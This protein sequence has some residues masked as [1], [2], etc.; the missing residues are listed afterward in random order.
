MTNDPKHV[1]GTSDRNDDEFVNSNSSPTAVA[2]VPDVGDELVDKLLWGAKSSS[3]GGGGN[4]VEDQYLQRVLA[5]QQQENHHDGDQQPQQQQQVAMEQAHHQQPPKKQRDS[6]QKGVVPVTSSISSSM[7]LATS[8]S[9]TASS[10]PLEKV[11]GRIFHRKKQQKQDGTMEDDEDDDEY[12]DQLS[13]A[14]MTT[15]T[16]DL[17]VGTK[18]VGGG[19]AV[20]GQSK[21]SP[22]KGKRPVGSRKGKVKATVA[23]PRMSNAVAADDRSGGG[24]GGDDTATVDKMIQDT[25]EEE[26]Q[27]VDEIITKPK[28]VRNLTRA[29]RGT[30][31]VPKQQQ[32][33]NNNNNE[34]A[35]V[36]DE[37]DADDAL[38]FPS[39]SQDGLASLAGRSLVDNI[40]LQMEEGSRSNNT[41][42]FYD[43]STDGGDGN[44]SGQETRTLRSWTDFNPIASSIASFVSRSTRPKASI[45]PRRR[46]GGGGGRGR[47][48]ENEGDEDRP[49]R[50][51]NYVNS[52]QESYDD[53]NEDDDDDDIIGNT[54]GD[55]N[56]MVSS[57]S[58]GDTYLKRH[59]FISNDENETPWWVDAISTA[60]SDSNA[61]PNKEASNSYKMQRDSENNIKIVGPE[62]AMLVCKSK[63][64]RPESPSSAQL[65]KTDSG[66]NCTPS[67]HH[68]SHVKDESDEEIF[69]GTNGPRGTKMK[70]DGCSWSSHPN[71]DDAVAQVQRHA[72]SG[73]F[74]FLTR[75]VRTSRSF[76]CV[77]AVAILLLVALVVVAWVA[78]TTS[79]NNED[80][81]GAANSSSSSSG[82]SAPSPSQIPVVEP[83]TLIPIDAG[84]DGLSGSGIVSDSPSL[85]AAPSSLPTDEG[86]ESPSFQGS[87]PWPT[88]SPT[89]SAPTPLPS[90]VPTKAPTRSP[91]ES[92]TPQPSP[93][94]TR[95]PTPPPT[96]SPT[97]NPTAS[98]TPAPTRPPTRPPTPRPVTSSP[99]PV[100]TRP[101][102]RSPT[103]RPV[104]TNPTPAPTRPPTRSP[105][106]RPVTTNP[107]PAPTRSPTPRPTP[108]PTDAGSL[109]RSIVLDAVREGLPDEAYSDALLEGTPQH[110]AL[111]WLVGTPANASFR[112]VPFRIVQRYVLAT[113]YFSTNGDRWSE[114]S[115]W[116][117]YD[118]DE[119]DWYTTSSDGSC[120]SLGRIEEI[121]LR[122]NNLV[123]NVPDEVLLLADTLVSLRVNDNSIDDITFMDSSRLARFS[124]L[125]RFH[126]QVNPLGGVISSHL[127]SLTS[128]TSLNLSRTGMDGRIPTQLGRL[129]QMRQLDFSTNSIG[130]TIPAQVGSMTALNGL[131]LHRNRLTG[132]IP[133]TFSQLTKIDELFLEGNRLAGTYQC[134]SSWSQNVVAQ[135]D[136]DEVS[137][138]CCSDCWWLG[139]GLDSSPG[140]GFSGGQEGDEWWLIGGQPE[141]EPAPEPPQQ[142]EEDEDDSEDDDE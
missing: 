45:A 19:G 81:V 110:D 114:S 65:L 22:R 11:F 131:Y 66:D 112:S 17:I 135:V 121:D 78:F 136:C 40:V 109:Y 6:R 42:N 20:A 64:L 74:A 1:D 120:D 37:D 10:Y 108:Q 46:G 82:D 91:T 70:N 89:T 98:P 102:T 26:N 41:D 47:G 32:Q 141:P 13:T 21:K 100:P 53:D 27:L 43:T 44:Y 126:V 4:K 94:L 7:S 49:N 115:G 86:T 68:S 36:A 24:G 2:A 63:G 59:I 61:S 9:Q 106:P 117:S 116:L 12:Y 54:E 75:K 97:R 28:R 133:T 93:G 129:T 99:T 118:L 83:S 48:V 88:P 8:D 51:Q 130:G 15:A 18:A 138:D 104:T 71:N 77:L 62:G 60:L 90:R 79:Q 107:T 55:Q 72:S 52:V 84:N 124:S 137:C 113:L 16:D 96:R 5:E 142:D 23:T 101:P 31:Y 29:L 57:L 34:M 95:A 87:T 56:T 92:P 14:A 25:L 67:T 85:S 58:D 35:N 69:F 132:I 127:G 39:S 134:P 105:T 111:T 80:I 50:E 76:R 30:N 140:G 139:Q 3:T 128:L 119:C 122:R 123:G 73:P 125:T 33:S 38:L 103:P